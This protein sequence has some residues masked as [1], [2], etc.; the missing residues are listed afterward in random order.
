MSDKVQL[1]GCIC[2]V[3]FR[4]DAIMGRYLNLSPDISMLLSILSTKSVIYL[5]S[6]R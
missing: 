2:E 4:Y 1:K 6:S 5:G 3:N